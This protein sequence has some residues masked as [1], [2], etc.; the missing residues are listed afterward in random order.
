M[1]L[2]DPLDSF[3]MDGVGSPEDTR[4]MVD[5]FKAAGLFTRTAWWVLHHSRKEK[6]NDQIDEASGAWGGRPDAMLGLERLPGNRA[7]LSFPKLR[8]GRRSGFAFILA[9]DSEAESFKFIG[10]DVGEERDYAEEIDELLSG[11]RE[12]LTAKEIAASRDEE[13]PGIGAAVD[14]V[15][16][17]LEVGNP[18]CSVLR[19]REAAKAVGRHPSSTIWQVTRSAKS[20]ESPSDPQGDLMEAATPD[21][22]YRESGAPSQ[23]TPLKRE[24]PSV[25]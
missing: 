20:P 23:V 2:G 1:I 12:W 21:L 9:F 25:A 4:K 3:G 18:I 22:P 6:V 17:E 15:K 19:T 8:W 5:R 14:K 13:S 24:A 10:E 11:R 7:R 16:A